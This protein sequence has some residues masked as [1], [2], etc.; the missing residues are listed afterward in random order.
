[1]ICKECK[2]PVMPDSKIS[3]RVSLILGDLCGTIGALYYLV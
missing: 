3:H 2:K 1:M